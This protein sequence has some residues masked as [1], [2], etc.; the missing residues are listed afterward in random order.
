MAE[1]EADVERVVLKEKTRSAKHKKTSSA[2]L[3]NST[4]D[5]IGTPIDSSDSMEVIRRLE[6]IKEKEAQLARKLEQGKMEKIALEKRLEQE[7][8]QEQ[9]LEKLLNDVK[10]K[11]LELAKQLEGKPGLAVTQEL[12]TSSAPATPEVER[13]KVRI[14]GEEGISSYISTYSKRKRVVHYHPDAR[15]VSMPL[16]EKKKKSDVFARLLHKK[17]YK[18]QKIGKPIT[19][20]DKSYELMFDMLLGIRVTVSKETAK[21]VQREPAASDFRR[22]I[23]YWVPSRGSN[24]TPAHPG[25]D[26]KFRDYAPFVFRQLRDKFNIDSADYLLSLTGDYILSEIVSPGKSGSF[27]YFS[28]DTRFMLKTITNFETKFLKKILPSYYNHVMNNPN[29]LLTRFFGFHS[30]KPHNGRRLHFVIMANIFAQCLDIHERYD[31]KGSTVGRTVGEA[32]KK[33][34]N[35]I[36]KD[37]DL[38]GR[39][40]CL[41]P[42]KRSIFFEQ[43]EKDCKYLESRNI[44]DYSLLLGIHIVNKDEPEEVDSDMVMHE[45]LDEVV[46]RFVPQQTTVFTQDAGGYGATDEHNQPVGEVYFMGIIDILQP[47]NMKKRLEHTFKSI[48]QPETEISSVEPHFYGQ[49]FLTFIK[50]HT[51]TEHA[52]KIQIPEEWV[53]EEDEKEIAKQKKKEEKAAKKRAKKKEKAERKEEKKLKKEEKERREKEEKEQRKAE[54]HARKRGSKRMDGPLRVSDDELRNSS[55]SSLTQSGNMITGFESLG[56]RGGPKLQIE[57]ET[58]A[59]RHSL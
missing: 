10:E 34:P 7:M 5:I 31:I 39:Y 9:D 20:D 41:G 53:T 14:D 58:E 48:S 33:E 29:T 49:R 52:H 36:L 26:F 11:G 40:I 2:G 44:M 56:S 54:K 24:T 16:T 22:K 47:Y 27:F 30:V 25:R 32:K 23:E 13:R 43:L 6:Q 12:P 55:R 28:H 37:L 8:K 38:D 35:V 59:E 45:D 17:K 57:I 42:E 3:I 15:P 4:K 18:A 19:K 21:R 46:P 1:A 50:L 51:S